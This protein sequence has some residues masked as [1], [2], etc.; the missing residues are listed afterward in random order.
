MRPAPN[1]VIRWTE[2]FAGPEEEDRCFWIAD[3]RTA[4]VLDEPDIE[5][6]IY[7]ASMTSG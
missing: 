5:T 1:T 2:L 3:R 4:V 7:L 6:V